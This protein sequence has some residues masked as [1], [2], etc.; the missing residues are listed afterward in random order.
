ADVHE[1]TT[2]TSR[3]SP[4]SRVTG[5]SSRSVR[6]DLGRGLLPVSTR[7]GLGVDTRLLALERGDLRRRVGERI[8]TTTG[9]GERD[10]V[11]DRLG[12]GQQRTDAVPAERDPAV[13]GR[14][15][16]EGVE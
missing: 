3:P 16:G 2:T 13:R 4:G 6:S 15:V 9:L 5:G 11:A 8:D 12:A 7:G 1:N 10:D 14:A